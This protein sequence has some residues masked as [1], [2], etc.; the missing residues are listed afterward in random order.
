MNRTDRLYAIREELRGAGERGRTAERLSDTFEVSVRTIKRDISALQA[1]GF[2]VWARTGRSGG[3]VVDAEATLP[4]VHLSPGEVSGLAVLLAGQ[5]GQPFAAHA[6]SA[7][8]KILAVTPSAAREHAERLARRV[9][10]DRPEPQQ[11]IDSNVR[12]AVEEALASRRTL[13]LNYV[14]RA[15]VASQRRVEPQ[16]LASTGGHWY[17]VAFCLRQ[18]AIRWFRLDRIAAARLTH[19][20]SADRA[21][22]EIG[23]PPT[24]AH[25]V[26][27]R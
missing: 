12:G 2:P 18:Q 4:P 27:P 9:W 19:H 1:S 26:T 16:L 22:S 13:A 24:T 25:P 3:Y 11:P 17:L 8:A 10:I 14:D 21:V 20:P 5:A 23:T 15:G 7:L 6:R